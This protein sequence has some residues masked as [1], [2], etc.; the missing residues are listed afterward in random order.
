MD[1]QLDDNE[2]IDSLVKRNKYQLKLAFIEVI[3]QQQNNGEDDRQNMIQQ[4]I[5]DKKQKIEMIAQMMV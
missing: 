4:M 2:W 3:S 1:K 5:N